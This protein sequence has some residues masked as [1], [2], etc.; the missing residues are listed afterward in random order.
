MYQG[1]NEAS[2]VNLRGARFPTP[3][4]NRLYPTRRQS[5]SPYTL[6]GEQLKE[7]DDASPLSPSPEQATSRP[8]RILPSSQ[9]DV[10]ATKVPYY[11]FEPL[12]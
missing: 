7:E 8:S 2:G 1:L 12:G 4:N 10:E 9:S 5:A 11:F 3:L 6:Q